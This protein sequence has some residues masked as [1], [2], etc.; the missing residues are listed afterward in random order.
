MLVEL[1]Q[2]VDR[3]RAFGAFQ[4]P[5]DSKY[6]ILMRCTHMDINEVYAHGTVSDE[7]C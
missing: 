6:G 2:P 1:S 5:D 4:L 3:P 7:S